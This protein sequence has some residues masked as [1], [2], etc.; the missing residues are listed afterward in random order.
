MTFIRLEIIKDGQVVDSGLFPY[1]INAPTITVSTPAGPN[2]YRIHTDRT[3][4]IIFGG[5][6]PD[7]V[8]VHVATE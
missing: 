2:S 4:W 7:I 8:R 3:E 5:G 1:F 6:A